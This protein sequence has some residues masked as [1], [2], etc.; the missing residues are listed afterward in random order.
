METIRPAT[1]VRK[2]ATEWIVFGVFLTRSL[3]KNFLKIPETELDDYLSEKEET[4]Y[5]KHHEEAKNILPCIRDV[6]GG[7]WIQ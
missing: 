5:F 4:L 1:R 3:L 7:D 2:K 6:H